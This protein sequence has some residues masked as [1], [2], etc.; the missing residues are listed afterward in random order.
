MTSPRYTICGELTADGKRIV[1]VADGTATSHEM[2][3]VAQRLGL[4]TPNVK[5]IDGFDALELPLSWPAVI[6]LS[7]EFGSQWRPGAGLTAWIHAE[8]ARRVDDPGD[9]LT[10]PVPAG[11][12]PRPYQVAGA[13]MLAAVGSCLITDE[14]GTGKTITTILG[15]RERAAQRARSVRTP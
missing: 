2:N 7:F 8:A 5:K 13:L 6:Q 14:P 1:L 10:A 15:I 3:Y 4:L 9:T 11:L 12:T